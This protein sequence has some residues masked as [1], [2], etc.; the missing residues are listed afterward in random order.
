MDQWGLTVLESFGGALF[1]PE[2]RLF[3]VYIVVTLAL[4]AAVYLMTRPG[5][6]FVAWLLPAP[7]WKHPSTRLDIKLF[8]LGRSFAFLGLFNQLAITNAASVLMVGALQG[9]PSVGDPAHPLLA[10]FL[11]LLANDFAVYWV[12]RLHHE[13]GRLWPFHAVHHSAE[14]MTPFTVYRKHPIYDLLSSSVRGMFYGFIQG[15]ILALFFGP[16]SMTLILGVNI[17]YFVFNLL[18]SNLRHTHVWLSYGPILEHVL[19]SPAQHQI[20]HSRA[21]RHHNKNY[22]EVL[23]IWDWMFGTLFV[24]RGAEVLEFGL[25]DEAGRALPQPHKTLT[26]ALVRPVLESIVPAWTPTIP[27]RRK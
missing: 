3:P 26:Q 11:I 16:V 13:Y 19:I 4:A 9:G 6:T 5:I 12:H 20:H 23:A 1:G 22:G 8:I 10:A 25:A 27:A 14:V 17:F 21:P 2:T 18:G 15:A 7:I 24:P